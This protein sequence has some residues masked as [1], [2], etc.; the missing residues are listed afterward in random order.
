M[1]D[2]TDASG[3]RLDARRNRDAVLTAALR[4]L[5][6]DPDAGMRRIAEESGVA[7]ATVYRRF[8]TREHLLRA[9]AELVVEEQRA[10]AVDATTPPAPAAEVLRRLG[11]GIVRVGERYRFAGSP[12]GD[13]PLRDPAADEPLMVWLT[14]AAAGGELR[15]DLPADWM[16]AMVHGLGRAANEEVIAGRRTTE[17]A[18]DLLGRTLVRALVA[19]PERR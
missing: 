9:L 14:E 6:A 2:A 5:A 4:I 7:R 13:A 15:A 3:L 16:Y 17:E 18:G 1:D 19:D 10:V 8:P 12:A 11:H